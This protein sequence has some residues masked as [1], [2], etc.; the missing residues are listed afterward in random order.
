MVVRAK[1][2]CVELTQT[3]NGEKIK[4]IPVS[5]GSKENENFFKWTP[6]GSIEI[7]TINTEAAKEFNVGKQYYVDFTLAE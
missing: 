7:G 6:Y 3:E 4:L 5:S 2:K 1:F